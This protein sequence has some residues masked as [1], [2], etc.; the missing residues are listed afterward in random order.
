MSNPHPQFAVLPVRAVTAL[1]TLAGA[2]LA[3]LALAPDALAARARN[4]PANRD[5]LV[6][7][8]GGAFVAYWAGGQRAYPPDLERLVTYWFRHNVA[9]AAISLPLLVVLGVLSVLLW[10][11]LITETARRRSSRRALASA[12]SLAVVSA[13][14]AVWTLTA[15]V[16]GAAAPFA[17]LLPMLQEGAHH[18]E[19]AAT[20][21]QV[22]QELTGSGAAAAGER[23]PVLEAML[24]DS[25]R[26]HVA[27]AAAAALTATVLLGV[28]D[29]L[30]HTSR[31]RFS[32]AFARRVLRSL[33]AAGVVL[34]LAFGVIL[35]ANWG[36]AADPE[37]SLLGLF[38]GGW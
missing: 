12:G 13:V 6:D 1:T 36:T 21:D 7:A 32:D 17:A 33:A 15:A 3:A 34:S 22:T 5:G 14:V 38:N 31:R 8:L 9:T 35:V 16:Q 20:L 29:R 2:L 24:D 28:S 26:F 25:A 4:S 37:P 27:H 10:R 30:W 18:G 19:L 23:R 11:A